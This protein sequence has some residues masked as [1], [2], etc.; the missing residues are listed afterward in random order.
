VLEAQGLREE[1]R[2]ELGKGRVKYRDAMLVNR[3]WK[4]SGK[5]ISSGRAFLAPEG[6]VVGEVR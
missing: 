6:M 3:M 2:E 4:T 1:R 5:L